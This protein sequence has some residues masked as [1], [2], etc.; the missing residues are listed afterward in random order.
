MPLT[1][2]LCLLFPSFRNRM[3][4]WFCWIKSITT[5]ACWRGSSSVCRS[6][7]PAQPSPPS[8]PIRTLLWAHC[9]SAPHFSLSHVDLGD[10]SLDTDHNGGHLFRFFRFGLVFSLQRIN[11]CLSFVSQRWLEPEKPLKKQ[12]K[13]IRFSKI[14]VGLKKKVICQ[15]MYSNSLWYRYR[16]YSVLWKNRTGFAPRVHP[17][18]GRFGFSLLCELQSTILHLWSQFTAAWTDEVCI[19]AS[20]P[21]V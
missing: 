18:L 9:S 5:W 17:F 21:C 8:Q 13:G 11:I 20:L 19:C 15:N 1:L 3:K 14:Y 7:S 12:I 10:C 4:G 6:E 16:K 2:L